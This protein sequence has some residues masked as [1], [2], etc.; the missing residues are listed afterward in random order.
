MVQLNNLTIEHQ[1]N[2][3]MT[4][5]SEKLATSL[6]ALKSLQIEGR[7]AIRS[8]DLTRT[9]RERLVT[10][11]FLQEV[12]KGWYIA[13]SPDETRGESTAWYASFWGFCATYLD[14]RFDSEWCLSPEQSLLLHSGNWSV[15]SQLLIR[16]PKA[17]NKVTNLPHE[18]SLLD[19]RATL[20]LENQRQQKE[21]MRLFSLESAL[22][23]CSANFFAQYSTDARAALSTLPDASSLLALL[24]EGGHSTIAGRLAGAFRN[25][26]RIRIA[27][28]IVSTMTSAGY[29]IREADPFEDKQVL[30]LARRD[31]S[32]YVNRIH[33]MW[34]MM[35]EPVIEHFPEAPGLSKDH[36]E[37][38]KHVE[39]V[40]ATDAYHSLSIEGYQVT[41]ELIE[42][43][44]SGNWNPDAS[45]EDR[46]QRNALAA[47]G[48]WQ[49]FQEVEKSIERILKG[50]NP[51][52]VAEEGNSTW[53]RELFAPSV[54]VGLLR[55]SDLAGY[56]SIPVYIRRSM[57][58]PPNHEAVRDI[59]PAFFELL[60]EEADPAVRVVLGHFVFVYI[61][62]Y[63]DGNGRI[64]RFLMNTMLASGGYP[65]TIVPVEK[66]Q[67]YMAALEHASVR[68]NIVPFA[69]FI[70]ELVEK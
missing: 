5:P 27:D 32:P 60:E 26:G 49:A 21:G 45:E 57:H 70:G 39:E 46:Q 29:T 20:P 66:R 15:P 61:H 25:I 55:P 58:V 12:M 16:H 67:E 31:L 13:A 38:M 24:L 18:T 52:V 56:R 53:Y 40:Y 51:G 14:E 28:D 7:V 33:L 36:A 48:Y 64:G 1:K 50:D 65:W 35:R 42:R 63:S 17:G 2:L 34:E 4:T 9:D 69:K 37:Y 59:M 47:R 22:I 3:N 6:E 23:A 8:G 30:T 11:G 43:V 41:P 54:T 44:R 19:I 68:Q 10:N 62:P